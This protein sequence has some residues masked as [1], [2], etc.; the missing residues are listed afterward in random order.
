L[1]QAG[2]AIQPKELKIQE[3][4]YKIHKSIYLYKSA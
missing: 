4:L 3:Q 1:F 2:P